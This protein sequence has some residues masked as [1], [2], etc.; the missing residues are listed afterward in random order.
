VDTS[1][2]A[3]LEDQGGTQVEVKSH[4]WPEMNELLIRALSSPGDSDLKTLATEVRRLRIANTRLVTGYNA[5]AD[6]I[7]V[8]AKNFA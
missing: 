7:K 3:G 1:R 8:N 4:D 5:L 2:L 6:S